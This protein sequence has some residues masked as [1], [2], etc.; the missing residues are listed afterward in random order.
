MKLGAFKIC[1][2]LSLLAHAA[3]FTAYELLRARPGP[4]SRHESPTLPVVILTREPD[5][6]HFSAPPPGKISSKPIDKKISKLFN[7]DSSSALKKISGATAKKS[8]PEKKTFSGLTHGDTDVAGSQPFADDTTNNVIVG[9][10]ITRVFA[11]A[12]IQPEYYKAPA[13]AYPPDARRLRQEGVVW[14]RVHVTD[15]GHPDLVTVL[16][17]SGYETLDDAAVRAVREWEFTPAQLGE[18]L[19]ESEIDFPIQFRLP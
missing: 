11:T 6:E 8:A 19:V 13:P 2:L 4:E 18:T 10:R 1:L 16:R 14:L 7:A 9:T 3:G 5:L 12:N 17:T 15:R